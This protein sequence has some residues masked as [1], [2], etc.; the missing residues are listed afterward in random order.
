MCNVDP[1]RHDALELPASCHKLQRPHVAGF[2]WR[3]TCPDCNGEGCRE[4]DQTGVVETVL[5]PAEARKRME[6]VA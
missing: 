4:C 5:A 6:G 1:Q 3:V 2:V